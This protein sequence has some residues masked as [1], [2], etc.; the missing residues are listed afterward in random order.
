MPRSPRIA[1]GGFVYHVVNR[2]N[3]RVRLLGRDDDFLAL[4]NVLL[5]VHARHSIRIPGWRLM[6][7]HWHFVV[8][9]RRDGEV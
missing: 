3:G 7:N 1:G 6:S 9:P 2:A 5:E 8:H 4:Y